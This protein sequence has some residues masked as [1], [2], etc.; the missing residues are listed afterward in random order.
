M[1]L[2]EPFNETLLEPFNETL[3][4][5]ISAELP[6]ARDFAFGRESAARIAAACRICAICVRNERSQ[7]PR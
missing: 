5:M 3:L 6:A 7:I 1:I 2:L 4:V